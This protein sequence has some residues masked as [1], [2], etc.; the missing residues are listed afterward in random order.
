[1]QVGA[2]VIARGIQDEPAFAWWVP[3]VMRKRDIIVSM[4]KSCV[5]WT[6]HKYGNEMPAPGRDIIQN[7]I[8]L[9]RKKSDTYWMDSLAKEMRNLN[10][11]VEYLELGE[12]APPGW[13]EASG[14]IVFDVK[15]DFTW[16]AWWVKDGHKTPDSTLQAL[17]VLYLVR[18]SELG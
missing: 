14:H 18:V 11:A 1:V 10:I 6:N 5:C 17:L 2:Y 3:Y 16:K 4:V 13:F 8:D 12:K 9:D 15:M 7:A